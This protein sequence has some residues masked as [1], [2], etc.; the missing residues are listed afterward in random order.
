MDL[1][2][3][4]AAALPTRWVVNRL[5]LIADIRSTPMKSSKQ[6]YSIHQIG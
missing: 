3:G 4:L 6:A 5:R 1:A 2:I